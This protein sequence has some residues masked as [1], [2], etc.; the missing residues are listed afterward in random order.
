LFAFFALLL[1]GTEPVSDLAFFIAALPVS[2]VAA[3][4]H[5]AR[6]DIILAAALPTVTD[7]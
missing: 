3:A 4:L 6:P 1:L 7:R 5:G 2:K